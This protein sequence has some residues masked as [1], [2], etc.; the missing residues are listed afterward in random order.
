MF[1]SF[2]K[3][4]LSMNVVHLIIIVFVVILIPISISD[5]K[6]PY[7]GIMRCGFETKYGIYC[8]RDYT[9]DDIPTYRRYNEVYD[10]VSYK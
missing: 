4:P 6:C 1:W 10:G 2:N 5:M 7:D 9:G 8:S 3:P